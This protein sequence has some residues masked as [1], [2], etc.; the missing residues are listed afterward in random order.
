MRALLAAFDELATITRLGSIYMMLHGVSFFFLLARFIVLC[1]FQPR[2]GILSRTLAAA[3]SD[4]SHYIL[5]LAVLF[6]TCTCLSHLVFGP[7]SLEFSSFLRAFK[8][9]WNMFGASAHGNS[10][11]DTP[12]RRL[13]PSCRGGVTTRVP[14]RHERDHA[15]SG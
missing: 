9:N 13:A 7:V 1:D 5:L 3:T 4:I 11:L 10:L 14:A 12:R 8:S 15:S 6:I 2:L